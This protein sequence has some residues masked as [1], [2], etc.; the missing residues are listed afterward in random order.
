VD[1]PSLTY[2]LGTTLTILGDTS[3]SVNIT[4]LNMDQYFQETGNT[5][6]TETG[7]TLS[8]WQVVD[9]SGVGDV[10]ATLGI[11]TDVAVVGGAGLS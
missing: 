4:G 5:V 2:D 6:Q 11:D 1:A 10:L 3:D 9:Y 8:I 7:E